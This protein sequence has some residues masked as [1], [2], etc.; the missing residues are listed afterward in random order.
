MECNIR[1]WRMEDAVDLAMALNNKNILDNL[2]TC[3]HKLFLLK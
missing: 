1:N 3:I 2:R